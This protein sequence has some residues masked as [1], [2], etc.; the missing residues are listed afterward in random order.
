MISSVS[1]HKTFAAA[2][3]LLAMSCCET[4]TSRAF[5]QDL[6]ATGSTQS[7]IE[8]WIRD[9]QSPAFA[10]RRTASAELRKAG[11][12]AIEPLMKALQSAGTE[13]KSRIQ[14]I[15]RELQQDTFAARLDKLRK[16]PSVSVAE[17]LPEWNR[18][19]RI[20]G[21][22]APSLNLYVRLLSAEPALFTAV[23]EKSRDLPRLVQA[24]AATL[25]QAA[26]PSPAR[27]QEFSIDSYAALL[28]LVSDNARRASGDTS[29]S[30][31]TLLG[32]KPFR[33]ALDQPDG[34]LLLR[35]AATYIMRD[36][37]AVEVPLDFARDF[38]VPEGPILA[39]RVLKTALRGHNAIFAMMLLK[40]QGTAEDIALLESLFND[41]GILVD[42][43]RTP[44]KNVAPTYRAYNGDMALAVAIAMRK[45]DPRDYGFAKHVSRNE[46]FYYVLET[47]GFDS[48]NERQQA[49]DKYEQ[50]F[51]AGDAA[52]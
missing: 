18:F 25:L 17:Q 23:M 8:S 6:S 16:T 22:D 35:L 41:K 5:S 21:T 30:V 27:T 32:Y 33:K 44:L 4:W 40:D 3:L 26:R 42:A 48:G 38:P 10:A 36:R 43:G 11:S 20:V 28:L 47:I 24:R 37:I 39:R 51:L 52:K 12:V 29:T 2:A 14:E 9:L 19:S 1:Y 50:Q 45:Q 7:A 46:D 13:Q 31:S 49:L 15:L 34:K